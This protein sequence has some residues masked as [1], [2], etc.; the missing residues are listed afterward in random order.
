M[1]EHSAVVHID[2]VSRHVDHDGESTTMLAPVTAVLHVGRLVALAGPSG[3]G[4]TTLCNILLGWD[5][6][7]SGEVRWEVDAR[8]WARLAVA[9]Q[10]LALLPSLTVQENVLLPSWA[11]ARPVEAAELSALVGQL[12]LEAVVHRQP[13]ELSFGEQQRA[14]VA[15]AVFGNPCV[16]VLD[17]PTGHQDERRAQRVIESLLA[18]RS[19]GTCVLVATHDPDLIDAADDVITLQSTLLMR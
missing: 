16:A 12:D 14:A 6:T 10:R 4:K 1:S 13:H 18:S 7:D 5:R 19:R 9:P 2:N 15:R 8:G 17:E 3:S 11:T